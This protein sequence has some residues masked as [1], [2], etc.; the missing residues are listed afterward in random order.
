M[1]EDYH[2]YEGELQGRML[3]RRKPR[4][5]DMSV[6]SHQCAFE[7]DE[8]NHLHARMGKKASEVHCGV[9][10]LG[11]HVFINSG[12]SVCW[13]RAQASNTF[14][15]QFLPLT[16]MNELNDEMISRL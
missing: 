16:N 10:R 2:D 1:D 4:I 8:P 12:N 9:N 14:F 11:I 7:C 15:S 6:A 3:V 5:L 13:V